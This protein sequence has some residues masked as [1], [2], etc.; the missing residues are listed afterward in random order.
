MTYEK[1]EQMFDG[2]KPPYIEEF[3]KF[4][5]NKTGKEIISI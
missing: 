4:I 5:K 3:R 1:A 2:I